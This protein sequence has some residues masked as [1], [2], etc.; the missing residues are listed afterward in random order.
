MEGGSS[1]DWVNALIAPFWNDSKGARIPRINPTPTITGLAYSSLPELTV[2]EDNLG[3]LLTSYTAYNLSPW[4]FID[5]LP[6]NALN[7]A[8][9][10]VR[11]SANSDSPG[12]LDVQVNYNTRF[13]PLAFGPG[14][15]GA[16]DIKD[17]LQGFKFAP[18]SAANRIFS[19]VC[20][21]A[22]G[23]RLFKTSASTTEKGIIQAF[24]NDR[25]TFAV[26]NLAQVLNYF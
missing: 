13:A 19:S 10:D 26:D 16:Y 18:K 14:D 23:Y 5:N 12:I 15:G 6:T 3:L 2:K 4:I 8:I 21:V 11:V 24:Y 25:G 7:N 17:M 20:L 9:T 1:R 22:S